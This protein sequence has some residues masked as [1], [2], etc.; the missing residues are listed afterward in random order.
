MIDEDEGQPENHSTRSQ[1]PSNEIHSGESSPLRLASRSNIASNSRD[2]KKRRLL[3]QR[4]NEVDDD[5]PTESMM[6]KS[7]QQKDKMIEL[8]EKLVTI[9]EKE[10]EMRQEDLHLKKRLIDILDQRQQLKSAVPAV[11]TLL[12]LITNS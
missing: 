10:M 12:N 4:L 1:T 3:N 9:K 2:P 5:Q 11:E 6:V 7:I 8:M